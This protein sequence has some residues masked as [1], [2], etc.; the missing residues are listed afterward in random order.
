MSTAVHPATPIGPAVRPM[1]ERGLGV[2]A[3]IA[4]VA[5]V[6]IVTWLAFGVSLADVLLFVGYALAFNLLPGCAAFVAI[7]RPAGFGVRE[8]AV[9]WG[10]GYGLEAGAFVLTAATGHRDLLPLYPVVV[11]VLAAPALWT[12]RGRLRIPRWTVAPSW[13]WGAAAVAVAA[14]LLTADGF[15]TQTPMPAT[16][17][18]VDYSA[19]VL[20]HLGFAAEALHHWPLQAPGLAGVQLHY[21]FLANTHMA[22]ISQVT[23]IDLVTIAFRLYMVPMVLLLVVQLVALARA[24]GA[25]AWAGVVA[26]ALALLLGS[27]DPLPTVPTELLFTFPLSPSFLMGTIIWL[28]I[29]IL[30]AEHLD[31]RPEALRL[32][33]LLAIAIP[34]LFVCEG[35]KAT[36]LPMTIAALAL[37]G[38][39]AFRRDRSR[40]PVVVG[41]GMACAAV[42]LLF[43]ALLYQGMTNSIGFHPLRAYLESQPFKLLDDRFDHS[44]LGRV[45]LYPLA[46]VFGTLRIAVTLLPGL[47]V[48]ALRHRLITP[49]SR[50]LLLGAFLTGI[51]AMVLLTHPGTSQLYFFWP[52]YIA[53]AVL[54]AIGLVHVLGPRVAAMHLRRSWMLG[55][56]AL[57]ALVL[58][59]DMPV[60]DQTPKKSWSSLDDG[61]AYPH[62]NNNMT[63][64]LYAG[65]AWIRDHTDVD[66]VLAVS[67]RFADA[68]HADPR[69]CEP[70][71]FAERRAMLSCPSDGTSEYY[72]RLK[73]NPER[74]ELNDAIF[75]AGSQDAV[76][77]AAQKFG[78]RWLVADR[79]HGPIHPKVYRL[80]RIAFRNDEIAVIEV[81]RH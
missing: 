17:P 56:A 40:L 53:G 27:L 60:W 75:T 31:R 51:A 39:W 65:Y 7:A 32:P 3:P 54:S 5:A 18:G 22:A 10:L 81:P 42:I 13:T 68:A 15:F 25:S 69:Y 29:L 45:L 34:L 37:V 6:C 1:P 11:L 61:V 55:G 64:Q 73:G 4:V 76:A 36:S 20:A 50:L 71:A 35:A 63:P 30:L 43:N 16:A 66:D 8:L 79:L 9:G 80:G 67:Q 46:L 28:P 62:P 44:E 33:A 52:G 74:F 2:S 72:G 12:L 24:V 49:P 23:G 78:V 77:F 58:I 38:L 19:D 70:S 41:A 47:A 21:Y 26:G 59:I 48:L 57:L 14:V